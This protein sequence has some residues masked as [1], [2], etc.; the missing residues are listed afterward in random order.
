[1]KVALTG[2]F[3]QNPDA[4]GSYLFETRAPFAN[5]RDWISSDFLLD[6]GAGLQADRRGEGAALMFWIIAESLR[7][8][9]MAGG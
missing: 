1:M 5:Q 6:S 8:K 2:L 4:G 7:R 9:V 3:T